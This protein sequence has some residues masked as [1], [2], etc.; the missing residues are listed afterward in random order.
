M[1]CWISSQEVKGQRDGDS[2]Q[3]KMPDAPLETTGSERGADTSY[4]NL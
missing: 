4:N 1:G 3:E 2:A